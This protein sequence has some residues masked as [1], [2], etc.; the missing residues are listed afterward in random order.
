MT[1]EYR[2]VSGVTRYK[3]RQQVRKP[4]DW[5][6]NC[7]SYYRHAT[8][9]ELKKKPKTKYYK[10][11]YLERTIKGKK[12]KVAPR[13][14][15]KTYVTSESYSVAPAWSAETRY[16]LV[17]KE[18]APGWKTDTYYTRNDESPP[19]WAKNNYYAKTDAKTA[20]AWSKGYYKKVTDR[21]AVMVHDAISKIEEA[22][23]TD[24]I[25]IS[26]DDTDAEYDVG[27]IV[28]AH[29]DVTGMTAVAEIIKKIIKIS[30]GNI[31]IKYEVK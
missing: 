12:V 14:Q 25:Q 3:Y 30:N 2:S 10:V 24:T 18:Q 26:L 16:T 1:S 15:K 13:W 31:E 20:P 29:E 6:T 17:S 9:A 8:A 21:Y 23:S 19:T 22:Y 28:G 4:T 27:D 5:D 11:E 7:E